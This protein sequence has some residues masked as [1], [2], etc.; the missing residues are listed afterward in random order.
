MCWNR[1]TSP[2]SGAGKDKDGD[3]HGRAKACGALGR[4]WG[5]DGAAWRAGHGPE[6]PSQRRHRGLPELGAAPGARWTGGTQGW[7]SLAKSREQAELGQRGGACQAEETGGVLRG[8]G[9]ARG[10]PRRRECTGPENAPPS[11]RRG[12]AQE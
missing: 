6:L 3:G 4:G 1:V 7:G 5:W 10:K 11:A 2:V 9:T 12:P 8:E